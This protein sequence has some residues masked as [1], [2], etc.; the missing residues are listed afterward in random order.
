MAHAAP[1]TR[2]RA[3]PWRRRLRRTINATG[4]DFG[5]LI[6]G[7]PGRVLLHTLTLTR[8]VAVIGQL[9]TILFVHFSLGIRLPLPAL[10]PA[11]ALSALINLALVLSLKATT[12]L[13]ERSA[14]TLFS[15]DIAQLCYLLALTGGIRN[16][17]T[18]LLLVPVALAAATLSLRTTAV[19]SGIGLLSLTIL[20]LWPN[21]LPWRDGVLELPPLYRLAL[22]ASSCIATLLISTFVWS[23]AEEARRRAEA[24]SV[25]QL[26]L[27]REQQM[28]ALGGQ[29]AAAAHLLGSPL[30][31]IN[32]IAKEL[33]NELPDGSP[34]AEEAVEL[35]AQAQRCRDLLKGLGRPEPAPVDHA[36]FTSLP[37]SAQLEAMAQEFARPGKTVLVE[38]EDDEEVEEPSLVLRPEVRHSLANLVDNAIRFARTA[39]TLTIRP[40]EET[41]V[42]VIQDDGPGFPPE[43]LD[44]LGEP[45]LST[46]RHEG[47]LG[48]GVF[49]ANT[50]LVRTGASIQFDNWANGA[51]VTITWPRT[52]LEDGRSGVGA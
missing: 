8:W 48:L 12:R 7:A 6:G 19:T 17:F 50:L 13:P 41:C 11:V 37:L 29:A 16:P 2:D 22:W 52:A 40:F 25:T 44:W 35:L 18:A 4:R 27:A 45:F 21:A 3:P 31:T 47:G 36:P 38:V 49:I 9:F 20:A 39:V 28:S 30:A 34:L 10:L 26:A 51:R 32:I 23:I 15:Y 24:L 42:L 33:V 46:R 14:V 1:R 43:V 5:G